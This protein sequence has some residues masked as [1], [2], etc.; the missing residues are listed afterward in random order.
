MGKRPLGRAFRNV[1]V[2]NISSSLGDGIARTAAPL[3]AARLTDDPLLVSG[4]A[5]VALLP[6]LLFAIPA[7]I[8]LD[9]IDRRRAMALANGIRTALAILLLALSATDTLTI[10]WLYLVLFVYG[11]FETV[12][13]GAIRAVLPSIVGK[14]DLPR[15][16]SRIEGGEIVVQNF[17]SGPLTSALFA[18]SVV[19]P[20]GIGALSFAVA[21]VLAVFLPFAAAGLHRTEPSSEPAV[22]WYRQFA[23]GFRFIVADPMLRN[24][25]SISVA[26]GVFYSAATATLVLYLL[27]RLELPEAWFGG[28]MLVAAIGSLAGASMATRLKERFRAGPVMAVAQLVALLAVVMMGAVPVLPVVAGVY[29]IAAGGITVWNILVMSLRQSAVPS[30]LLGRVHGTWRTLLWGTMP[31]GSLLGGLLGRVDLRAPFLIAGGGAALIMVCAFRF[32]ARL[33]NPEELG[34]VDAPAAAPPA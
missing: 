27:D 32:I 1:L 28:I 29:M 14:D 5:A 21:A 15:A 24:L 31:L 30:R 16:N 10:W 3:L 7:G 18:V 4:I 2:A 25:W 9:R 26:I 23:D 34:D 22:A 13:D 20:L 12:Y 33:P 8:L 11:M 6:W 17:L 19:I